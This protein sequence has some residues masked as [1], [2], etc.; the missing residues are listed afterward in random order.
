MG[1]TGGTFITL[2]IILAVVVVAACVRLLGR[3][4]G[5]T[6]RDVGTRTGLIVA[7]Q[8]A[9]LFAVLVLVNSWGDFYATWGDLFGTNHTKGKVTDKVKAGVPT[10]RPLVKGKGQLIPGGGVGR[11][12]EVTLGGQRTGLNATAYVVVP[13]EYLTSPTRRFPAVLVLSSTPR[14]FATT[15]NPKNFPAVY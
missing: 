1:L 11:V 14:T 5:R 6:L 15:L 8:V 4:P 3:V 2:V 9:T 13:P 12:D 10:I 7:T